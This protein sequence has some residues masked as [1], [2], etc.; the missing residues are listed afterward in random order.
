M[1]TVCLLCDEPMAI[2][3]IGAV[4]TIGDVTEPEWAP[5]CR[6]CAA[7]G[8]AERKHRRDAIMIRMLVEPSEPG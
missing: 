4:V 1:Q 3:A 6:R 2:G 7:L 8:D 5:L